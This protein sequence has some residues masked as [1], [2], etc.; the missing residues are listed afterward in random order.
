MR[1]GAKDE[2][3]Q[4]EAAMWAA[5]DVMARNGTLT[6][7]LSSTYTA[8]ALQARKLFEVVIPATNDYAQSLYDEAVAQDAAYAALLKS[9]GELAKVPELKKAAEAFLTGEGVPSVGNTVMPGGR[10]AASDYGGNIGI[11]MSG[12]GNIGAM[13]SNVGRMSTQGGVSITN[14]LSGILLSTDPAARKQLMDAVSRAVMESLR[15]Q[16]QRMPGGA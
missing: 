7:D 9:N 14:N 4:R 5:I 10:L 12:V 11:P 8:L 16:G 3:R 2:I 6:D 13:G 15:T 1:N